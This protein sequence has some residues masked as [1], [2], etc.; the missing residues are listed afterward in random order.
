MQ[1]GIFITGTDTE[2]GK[3]IVTA[4]L[5]KLLRSKGIDAVP[6]KPVQTGCELK[7]GKFIAPDLDFDIKYAGLDCSSDELNLM[8]PYCYEPAC[9][10]HL[11]G[12]LSGKYP[13]IDTIVS[14]LKEL[15][16]RKELVLVEGAGGIMVP[17]N[18]KEMM[19]DLMK[20]TAYPVIIVAHAELGTINHTLLS[21]EA[22]RNSGIE[23][24]GVIFNNVNPPD[25]TSRFIRE[26]NIKT[27]TERGKVKVLGVIDHIPDV[28]NNFTGI[29]KE[30]E[31][32]NI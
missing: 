9:S 8:A 10:P 27:I 1:K 23:I 18:E 11:A 26:D 3:T 6:M 14:H 13:E 4:G 22:L 30:F 15:E 25:A 17:L 31:Q 20:A 21:I 29:E 28:F 12:D 7:D 19:I 24:M 2:V 16:K 32:I 5:L